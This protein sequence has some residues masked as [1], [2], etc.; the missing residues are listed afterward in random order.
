MSQEE[1]LA[2]VFEAG[3]SID[4]RT[5]FLTPDQAES[6]QSKSKTRLESLVYSYYIGT[7]DGKILGTAFF[8]TRLV[9]TM[10]MTLMIVVR[11]DGTVSRVEVLS[12]FEPE[13]Y[14]P[15]RTWFDLLTGRK[16]TEPV[17]LRRDIPNVTGATLTCQAVADGLRQTLALHQEI[18]KTK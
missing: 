14:L 10:P 4:R 16:H 5:A 9:R 11:P 7:R 1:A 13:D 3:A 8:E 18:I 2:K 17:R 6:I 12:F 15:R